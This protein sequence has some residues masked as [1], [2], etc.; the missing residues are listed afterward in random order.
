MRVAFFHNLPS[1]GALKTLYEKIS[2]LESRGTKVSLYTFSTSEKDF[3]PLPKLSGEYWVEPIERAAD[4][5][6]YVAVSEKLATRINGG[7]YDLVYVDKCQTVGAPSVLRYLSVPTVYYAHEPLGLGEY[8]RRRLSKARKVSLENLISKLTRLGERRVLKSEDRRNLLA[9]THVWTCSRFAAD[10]IGEVYGL[11]PE[12]VYQGIDTN[13]L[14]PDSSVK[15]GN[16]LLS[17]GR[18]EERKGFH[19]VLEALSRIPASNRPDLK[20][21]YDA[22]EPG[23]KEKLIE[24]ARVLGVNIEWLHRPAQNKLRE[25]YRSASLVLGAAYEEPFGLTPLEAMA[26]G[27]PVVVVDEGGYRESVVDGKT[28]RLLKRD[29]GLWAREIEAL[30][31]DERTRAVWGRAAAEM[32]RSRWTWQEFVDKLNRLNK[33]E[34]I[35]ANANHQDS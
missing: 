2:A 8:S 5:K 18:L 35:K 17:V 13:F 28:G 33:P 24:E 15:K 32:A 19:F 20:I 30:L 21:V 23:E 26:C 7:S 9:A 27:T 34:E 6:S 12:P 22:T 14:F 16:F 10:W 25:L 29:A 11:K 31:K 1:G 3:L 4:L